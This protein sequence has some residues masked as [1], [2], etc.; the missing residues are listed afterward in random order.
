MYLDRLR[1]FKKVAALLEELVGDIDELNLAD[2]VTLNQEYQSRIDSLIFAIRRH[3]KDV[4]DCDGV[5]L[6]PISIDLYECIFELEA[7]KTRFKA[8][9][10]TL[11]DISDMQEKMGVILFLWKEKYFEDFG[12]DLEQEEWIYG[13]INLQAINNSPEKPI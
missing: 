3:R 7:L 5:A 10:I 1:E 12:S 8:I 6:R 2:F 4:C 11:D 9:N 13:N